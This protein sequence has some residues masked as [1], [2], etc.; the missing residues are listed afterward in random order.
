[1]KKW[2][3]IGG[4]GF[5]A[6]SLVSVPFVNAA[7]VEANGRTNMSYI[8]FVSQDKYKDYI[9]RA[10]NSLNV[11]TPHYFSLK[12]DGSL[13]INTSL[14]NTTFINDMHKK[15]VKVVPFI[16]NAWGDGTALANRDALAKQIANAIATYNL[17]GVNIDLEGLNETYRD[18]YTDFMKKL[19]MQIP[20][21]KQVSIAVAANPYNWT[22]GW[23][24]S[25]DYKKLSDALTGP[26]DYLMVMAYDE[27]YRGGPEG[28]VASLSFVEDSITYTL[29]KQVP[30]EKIVLGIPFYGRIWGNNTSF[31]GTG[32]SHHQINAIMDQYKGT[33][34]VTF[35]STSQTPK[36]TFTMKSGDPTFR[37]A[38]KDLIPGTY[39][40]WFDNE[41]SLKKKLILVQKYN[42]RGTGSWSLSQEDP[43]MWNYY[44]LW[45]NADYF[46]DV[47]DHW[48]QADIYGVNVRDWMIGTASNQ[49]EPDSTLTRAMGATLLVRAMGYENLT[50]LTTF[51]FN[52]VPSKHWAKKNI[53]IAKEKGLIKGTS[54][55]TFE[56]DKPL[57]REQAAQMLDNLLKYPNASL[58]S[59]SPFKDIQP[60]QWSYQAII[61]MN[62]NKIINGYTDGTFQPKKNVSRAEMAKLMNVSTDRIDKLVN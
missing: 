1:M 24:G 59:L 36:L 42:L 58:P 46:K 6:F 53:H 40:I 17:D 52:D 9:D 14:I 56:P 11:V 41:K 20:K 13:L 60:G 57:T 27:S 49:F 43:Q 61:N 62:K 8:S 35:D 18:N 4:S 15:G 31:N 34:K 19:R 16:Q 29:K 55:T 22:T 50:P 25:Y 2:L 28:P 39:T 21:H 47:I 37:I 44:N 10:Q 23:H 7:T 45:L 48:A 3:R 30:A 38:G 32:V 26:N 5:L 12:S 54:S 51:P 33:A